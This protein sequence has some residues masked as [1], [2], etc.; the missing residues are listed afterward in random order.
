MKTTQAEQPLTPELIRDLLQRDA[1][2]RESAEYLRM[3]EIYCVVKAGGI[4]EQVEVARRLETIE[5]TALQEEIKA[6][7][8][9][10]G[11]DNRV[12]AL[13]QEMQELEQSIASRLQY[14][15]T[16][17]TDEEAIVRICLPEVDAYFAKQGNSRIDREKSD[18]VGA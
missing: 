13:E 17:C 2:V 10:A 6:L 11:S 1:Q 9:Q 14:L 18:G 12:Q 3:M 8:E 7:S 16:I 5:K 15:S 4:A